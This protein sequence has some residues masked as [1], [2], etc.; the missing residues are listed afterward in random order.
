MMKK[1][2]PLLC[3]VIFLACTTLCSA[4]Y[5]RTCYPEKDPAIA[6]EIEYFTKEHIE[7]LCCINKAGIEFYKANKIPQDLF[8]ELY[9]A[10]T[11]LQGGT[12]TLEEFKWMMSGWWPKEIHVLENGV[13]K[14]QK[15]FQLF[16]EAFT[17]YIQNCPE[18]Y[19]D[20]DTTLYEAF[21][22]F[23]ALFGICFR[24]NP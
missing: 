10:N 16:D 15:V 1:K 2:T 21:M 17:A 19:K 8:M 20:P 14:T 6:L 11:N 7:T 13:P 12:V 22:Y 24:E 18:K 5:N 3:I 23:D 4:R 9:Q